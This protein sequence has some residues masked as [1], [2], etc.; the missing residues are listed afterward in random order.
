M[1]R[2]PSIDG[3]SQTVEK[4]VR[5]QGIKGKGTNSKKRHIE[6]KYKAFIENALYFLAFSVFAL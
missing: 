4:A 2:E 1:K 6:H 3:S 5:P